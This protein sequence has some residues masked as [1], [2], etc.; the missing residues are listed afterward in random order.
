MKLRILLTGKNGQ[1]GAKLA[2]LLPRLGEVAAFDRHELDLSN[3]DRVRRAI[4]DF[5]PNLIVNA[6]AY[7]SVDQAEREERQAHIINADAPALMAE[8]AKRIGAL[9]VHYSTDY[10]FDGSNS[11]P[12]A[13]TDQ[14][15]PIN[16]YGKTKLAGEEAIRAVGAPHLIFR[17]AWV[18]GTTGRNFL[19]TILR[20]AT[21]REELKVV[22]DQFGAPTWSHEIANGTAKVLLE[23]SRQGREAISKFGGIYHMT[24]AGQT[25]WFEFAKAILED[26]S[27][28]PRGF[29][30]F[31]TA[32][33]GQPLVTRRVT[34][35]TTEE[36]PTPARRPAYSVLSNSRLKQDF[37]LELPAWPL[38]LR[39]VFA[40][41]RTNG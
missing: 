4:R 13:E 3:P 8:E 12:Y 28:M 25:S 21:E 37:G 1:I 9:L 18:Y 31:E 30:W 2:V 33:K 5:Q 7:T 14:P 34:A 16:V 38:Q 26:A 24:A 22:R 36:Y 29:P 17:T 23:L 11:S 41:G 27:Q 35:I 6:A 15:N 40:E 39:A 32:T 19:L 20:L 10:V